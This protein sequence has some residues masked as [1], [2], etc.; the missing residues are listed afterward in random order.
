MVTLLAGTFVAR[1]PCTWFQASRRAIG[2]HRRAGGVGAAH[3]AGPLAIEGFA[4]A[5]VIRPFAH[6]HARTIGFAPCLSAQRPLGAIEIG[7]AAVA[8]D[9][10]AKGQATP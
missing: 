5:A 2:A 7:W 9:G 8:V 10:A 6:R 1:F 4:Q 3:A